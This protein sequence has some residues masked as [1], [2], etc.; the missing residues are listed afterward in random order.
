MLTG[1]NGSA[2]ILLTARPWGSG[3]P[4]QRRAARR[5]AR[6]RHSACRSR[7]AGPGRDSAW[8]GRT[9]GA[10]AMPGRGR[11]PISSRGGDGAARG[12]A[13]PGACCRPGARSRPR[14][15]SI[16]RP[17]RIIRSLKL[18]VSRMGER[19]R[20]RARRAGA[21][22]RSPRATGGPGR[23][24]GRLR[25]AACPARGARSGAAP[26]PCPASAAARSPTP[27][28]AGAEAGGES[29]VLLPAARSPLQ[30][31]PAARRT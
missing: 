25:R 19:H 24:H 6:R 8:R 15:R 10:A 11:G 22:E 13:E 27:G 21:R 9:P 17:R 28:A 16:D 12:A 18:T 14:R 30:R 23:R 26:A 4:G 3:S 2:G 20:E 7:G 5:S 1:T 29:R 31:P